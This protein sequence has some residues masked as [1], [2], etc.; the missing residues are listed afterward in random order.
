MYDYAVI[1]GGCDN[2]AAQGGYNG[3]HNTAM[4]ANCGRTCYSNQAYATPSTNFFTS[5]KLTYSYGQGSRLS[6]SYNF[7]GNQNR[8]VISDGRTAGSVSGSNVATLNWNQTLITSAG[9]QLTLD[10]SASRQ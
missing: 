8:G 10:V 4:A 6:L 5:D 1:Q 7:S 9:H 3:A 2:T